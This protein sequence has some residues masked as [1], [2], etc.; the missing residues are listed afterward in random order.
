VSKGFKPILDA[1]HRVT[2]R[3]CEKLPKMCPNPFLSKLMHSFNNG[4]NWATSVIFKQLPKVKNHPKSE[5][6]PNL[7]TLATNRIYLEEIIK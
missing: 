4:K 2:R 1:T 3:V 7:V 6:S 5:N